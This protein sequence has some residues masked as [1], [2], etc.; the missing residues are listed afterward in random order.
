MTHLHFTFAIWCTMDKAQTKI[1][2]ANKLHC[3]K[4]QIFR[5][6]VCL[7]NT[8]K[9]FRWILMEIWNLC[10]LDYMYTPKYEHNFI[11][12]ILWLICNFYSTFYNTVPNIINII[13]FFKWKN[14]IVQKIVLNEK[15]AIFLQFTLNR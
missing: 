5:R 9:L 2:L 6:I 7:F 4:A 1:I 10:V 3:A 13:V 8:N 11:E 12:F 15:S 14:N